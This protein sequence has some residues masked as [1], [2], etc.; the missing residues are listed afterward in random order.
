MSSPSLGRGVQCVDGRGAPRCCTATA[1]LSMVA[2]AAPAGERLSGAAI[3]WLFGRDYGGGWVG[4][5]FPGQNPISARISTL[6]PKPT[7]CAAPKLP[8]FQAIQAKTATTARTTIINPRRNRLV[9]IAQDRSRG[10]EVVDLL[11][12]LFVRSYVLVSEL[13][14]GVSQLPSKLVSVLMQIKR[15]HRLNMGDAPFP[16]KPLIAIC[17]V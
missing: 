15:H 17:H 6:T 4:C 12:F 16:N 13:P 2:G 3:F 9:V 10:L 7:T 11:A 1:S 5:R 8:L 14:Y